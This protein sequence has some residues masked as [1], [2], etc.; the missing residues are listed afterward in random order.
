MNIFWEF[1]KTVCCIKA[2][3]LKFDGFT[4]SPHKVWSKETFMAAVNFHVLFLQQVVHP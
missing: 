2:A 4:I 1:K 3:T